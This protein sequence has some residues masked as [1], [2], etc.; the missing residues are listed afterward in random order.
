MLYHSP[1]GEA[2]HVE[3]AFLNREADTMI[4]QGRDSDN[5]FCQIVTHAY[6]VQLLLKIVGLEDPMADRKPIGFRIVGED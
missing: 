5:N 2:I 6:G 3:T 4:F 1:A